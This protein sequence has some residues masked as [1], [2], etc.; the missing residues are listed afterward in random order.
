MK[1][2]AAN[3]RKCSELCTENGLVSQLKHVAKLYFFA[4]HS[5]L[6]CDLSG[7]VESIISLNYLVIFLFLSHI[8]FAPWLLLLLVLHNEMR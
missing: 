3:S 2:T 5:P 6:C 7:W 8:C 1:D 4:N